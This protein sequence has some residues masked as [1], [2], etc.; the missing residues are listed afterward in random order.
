[1]QDLSKILTFGSLGLLL[2]ILAGVVAVITPQKEF[3][4]TVGRVQFSVEVADN[5]AAWR[6]GLVGHAP[7]K[8]GEGMLF[9]FPTPTQ[10]TFWMKDM[11][12]PIDIIWIRDGKVIGIAE[13]A[14]PDNG[15]VVY[16][17]PGAVDSVLEVAAGERKRLGIEVGAPVHVE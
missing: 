7:L 4:V 11:T 5:P 17:S 1:M 6:K 15:E 12:Y 10:K 3:H 2:L 8:S 16:P 9:L 13:D 14:Q